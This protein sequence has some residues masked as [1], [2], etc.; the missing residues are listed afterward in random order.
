MI[1]VKNVE[2]DENYFEVYVEEG[3]DVY[4]FYWTL[5]GER[6][7]IDKLVTEIDKN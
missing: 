2:I 3:D 1:S 5:T 4:D 7:D 6:K